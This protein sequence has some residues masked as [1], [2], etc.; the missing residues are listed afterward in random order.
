MN[1]PNLEPGLIWINPEDW[2]LREDYDKLDNKYRKAIRAAIGK[3]EAD[4]S[5]GGIMSP[6]NREVA[7]DLRKVIDE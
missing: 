6:R 5:I 3:L 2:C 4:T 1:E 7:N